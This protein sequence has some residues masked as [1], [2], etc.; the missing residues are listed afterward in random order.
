MKAKM[1]SFNKPQRS[2]AWFYAAAAAAL[3]V[4]GLIA[5]PAIIQFLIN[6]WIH[7]PSTF[8]EAALPNAAAKTPVIEPEWGL[9]TGPIEA[10]LH[11]YYGT[12]MAKSDL[13]I[14][15]LCVS[16]VVAAAFKN[17]SITHDGTWR[18]P[19]RSK[20][21]P[22]GAYLE[23]SPKAIRR[24]LDSWD[25]KS[26]ANS[27]MVA[28][29]LPQDNAYCTLDAINYLVLGSMGG[30]KTRGI[31]I[32]SICA[33]ISR[34]EP[35]FCSDTKGELRDFTEDCARAH[36]YR[37]IALM[38]NDPTTSPD[39]WNPLGPAI[40]AARA[41]NPFRID[42]A[43]AEVATFA[44]FACPTPA[45]VANP[46]WTDMG[47]ALI[48][49][50]A[51]YTVLNNELTDD[52]KN[53]STVGAII[54]AIDD[55]GVTPL[56]RIRHLARTLE[57][58]HPAKQKLSQV[59]AAPDDTAE[60]IIATAASR[61]G[62]YTDSRLEKMLFRSSFSLRELAR[63]RT[64]LYVSFA[65]S[66]G[67]FGGLVS[68][69][70]TQI[71]ST[72]MQLASENGGQLECKYHLVLEEFIQFDRMPNLVSDIAIYR[73]AGI[74]TTL[75]IQESSMLMAKG[76]SEAEARSILASANDILFLSTNDVSS[77]KL[78]SDRI[79][80][81]YMESKSDSQSRSSRG[82]TIFS[83]STQ[84][85]QSTGA[86]LVPLLAPE[87]LLSWDKS[88]GALLIRKSGVYALPSPDLSET[89]LNEELGL[90]DEAHNNALRAWKSAARPAVNT[91]P[92]PTWLPRVLQEPEDE[93]D[94]TI[95]TGAVAAPTAMENYN[96][97][98]LGQ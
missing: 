72:L 6:D 49:G 42:D 54:T 39:T 31:I 29:Y 80:K 76:Y 56:V 69:L 2:P 11:P 18:G 83:S 34:G 64:I 21:Q 28:G 73:S 57:A 13:G 9:L 75:V 88:I 16:L 36:G 41:N 10:I 52:Q 74:R 47:R 8:I 63:P 70:T 46:F 86:Q 77:A 38:L 40:E 33:T 95:S 84:S 20:E 22:G 53:L 82:G 71:I 5:W 90:G 55:D 32:P 89:W 67:S 81:Y 4:A 62:S 58:G 60:S 97:L 30:N 3:S 98:K 85:G 27:C 43:C 25:G 23:S 78:L 65:G 87:D 96:P 94:D 50:V 61:L 12:F 79:G 48:E 93:S 26:P 45:N 51:L 7:D 92:A 17:R 68:T 35:I 44:G 14:I 37:V 66:R 59:A 19:K 91:R 24:A 15:V 1:K